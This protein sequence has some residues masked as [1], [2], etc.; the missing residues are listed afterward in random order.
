MG[1]FAFSQIFLVIACR[2]LPSI[3]KHT[4]LLLS[5][6]FFSELRSGWLSGE[7]EAHALNLAGTLAVWTQAGHL[8]SSGLHPQYHDHLRHS[9]D[10]HRGDAKMAKSSE[11]SQRLQFI[12]Y[13]F[14]QH[15]LSLWLRW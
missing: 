4:V 10:S 5:E 3:L 6:I 9:E 2:Y 11:R 7:Q 13:K 12:D 14:T 8:T 1:G 15:E